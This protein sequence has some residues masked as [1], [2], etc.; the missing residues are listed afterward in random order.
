[1]KVNYDE[2]VDVL[3]V[4]FGENPSHYG[5]IE[6]REVIVS[7][8]VSGEVIGITIVNAKKGERYNDS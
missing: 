5:R 1:M 7:Y 4:N 3:Y 6:S 2:E 8:S